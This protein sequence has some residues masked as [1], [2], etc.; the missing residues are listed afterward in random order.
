MLTQT[1]KRHCL[2]TTAMTFKYCH[3]E[4][5]EKQRNELWFNLQQLT[6]EQINHHYYHDVEHRKFIDDNN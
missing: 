6:T 1:Q 3:T 4:W 2:Y 5:T